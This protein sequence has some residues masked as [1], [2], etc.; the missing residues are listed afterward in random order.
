MSEN[1]F[2]S[3]FNISTILEIWPNKKLEYYLTK[4]NSLPPCMKNYVTMWIWFYNFIEKQ[5]FISK[6]WNNSKN[7]KESTKEMSV[8][9]CYKV[10]YFR[11]D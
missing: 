1:D 5:T 2:Y 7:Y 6:I 8:V 4:C 10:L 9:N 3:H 11:T